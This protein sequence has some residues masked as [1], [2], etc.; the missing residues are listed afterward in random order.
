MQL[1]MAGLGRMGANMVRRLVARGHEGVAFDRSPAAVADLA[2]GKGVTGASSFEDMMAK[3][4]KPRGVWMMIP[5]GVVDHAIGAIAPL[6]EPD[7]ILIDGGNSYYIDYIRRSKD[8]AS[9]GIR[10]VDVG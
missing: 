10:D 3:L 8:L 2:K 7:D 6:L 9:K 1:G 5:A 4:P